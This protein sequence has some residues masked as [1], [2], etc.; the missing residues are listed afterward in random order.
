MLL[1]APCAEAREPGAHI[2]QL[3]IELQ[4]PVAHAPKQLVRVLMQQALRRIEHLCRGQSVA[5]DRLGMGPAHF[6]VSSATVT[7]LSFGRRS[8][9][10]PLEAS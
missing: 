4:R 2:L 7:L 6:E 3:R 8:A 5:S 1:R 9:K 10:T